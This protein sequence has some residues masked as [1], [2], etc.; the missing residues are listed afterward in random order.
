MAQQ[1]CQNHGFINTVNIKAIVKI[2]KLLKML[3]IQVCVA[4]MLTAMKVFDVCMIVV[5]A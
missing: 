3:Y 4:A 1:K 2:Y 5:F